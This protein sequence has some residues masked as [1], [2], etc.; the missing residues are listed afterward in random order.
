MEMALLGNMALFL[1]G[2]AVEMGW[3]AF[4]GDGSGADDTNADTTDTDTLDPDVAMP[5]VSQENAPEAS[6]DQSL[7]ATMA[8]GTDLPE[9]IAAEPTDGA[10]ALFG[11]DGNDNVLG[12]DLNDWLEGDGGNDILLGNGG[13]DVLWGGTGDDDLYGLNGNDTLHGGAGHDLLEGNVGE[14]YLYG[15]DGD[16][17]LAGGGGLDTLI[18]GAGNDVLMSDRADAQADYTRGMGDKLDGQDGDDRLIFTNGDVVLGGV[19]QDLMQF[20]VQNGVENIARLDDFS[21]SEDTLQIIYDPVY[22]DAG[23]EIV[24]TLSFVIAADQNATLVYMNDIPI[25]GLSGTVTNTSTIELV[26]QS[27]DFY[28]DIGR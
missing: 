2:F 3:L 8:N 13:D 26:P 18:G 24:P 25:A 21:P 4:G 7:F 23:Q 5:P 28:D 11:Y 10:V 17:T 20:M 6:F 1:V 9:E 12:G 27:S 14:D 19:G 15:F 16:D 22:D